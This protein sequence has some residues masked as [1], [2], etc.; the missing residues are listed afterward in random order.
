M[1]SLTRHRKMILENMQN[2]TDHPTAK[3]VFD[4]IKDNTNKI[5][6]ATVYNTLE[7]LTNCGM[8]K[9]L[10]INS[11]SVRYDAN[12]KEHSHLI[13]KTCD[14]MI[15]YKETIFS[16]SGIPNPQGFIIDEI[17]VTFRGYCDTCIPN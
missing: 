9:K 11:Q 16:D 13:C 14:T 8:I 15:D 1:K 7:Y 5:S 12:L 6:F 2:R 3:M 17:S 4:S 10:D